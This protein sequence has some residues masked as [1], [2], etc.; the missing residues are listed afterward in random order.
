[1]VSA[2]VR[3]PRAFSVLEVLIA[4]L[5]LG[6]A[7]LP[8]LGLFSSTG[9]EARQTSDYALG[10]VITEKVAEEMRAEKARL[11]QDVGALKRFKGYVDYGHF[12]PIQLAAATALAECDAAVDEV[13]ETYRARRDALTD[14]LAGA[15]WTIPPAAATMFVWAPVPFGSSVDFALRLLERAR[16]AVAPGVGFGPGGEG[17]VRF[18]LVEEVERTREACRRI[19]AAL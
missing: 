6:L 14:G 7:V 19:A 3:R 11:R 18:A 17:F 5:I 16:V 9:M 1:M 8:V 13:K 12:T 15:G 2:L 10:I 4:F